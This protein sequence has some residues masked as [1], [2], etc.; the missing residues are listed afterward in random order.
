MTGN[1]VMVHG[2]ATS[3]VWIRVWPILLLSF[4]TVCEFHCDRSQSTSLVEGGHCTSRLCR[5]AR[6]L[7]QQ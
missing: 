5:S 4:P 6:Q 3:V 7:N 1:G 2:V